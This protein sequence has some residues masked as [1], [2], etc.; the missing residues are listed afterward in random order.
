MARSD[1]VDKNAFD[2][3]VALDLWATGERPDFPYDDLKTICRMAADQIEALD[4]L[5]E[6]LA[7]E[8]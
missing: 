2:L 5:C 7:H 4:K 1:I 6:T 3:A 8:N